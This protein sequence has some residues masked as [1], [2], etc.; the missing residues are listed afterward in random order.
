MRTLEIDM[1][2]TPENVSG[3]FPAVLGI[4]VFDAVHIGHRKIVA[5]ATVLAGK[6]GAIPVAV[7]FSP[8]PRSVVSGKPP[9]ILVPEDVRMK[10][11]LA[12]GA[13]GVAVVRFTRE[14]AEL[15]AEEFLDRL[16]ECELFE[17]RGICV[18]SR[19]RFGKGGYGDSKILTRWCAKRGVSFCPV[20]EEMLDERIISSTEIRTAMACG[21]IDSARTMLGGNPMLF[22]EVVHGY[23]AGARE[24][25]TPTANLDVRY[26]VIP[27]DG[28]Y[29]AATTIF[30]KRYPVAL[31]IGRAPT[32]R[33]NNSKSV[34]EA[35][36]V[37][38]SGDIYGHALELEIIRRL[39]DEKMFSSIDELKWQIAQDI[40]AATEDAKK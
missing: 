7:T 16:A 34:V 33:R 12:A 39:R 9:A 21:E 1:P 19:W 23:A 24:M 14:V 8:H 13:S 30:G 31:D 32:F 25:N 35:H 36:I 11:L 37:G 22:G 6:S 28:V 38:F 10:R 27:P 20:S 29:T 5:E 15:P 4:G 3:R 40:A 18:G 2:A 26:G 17:T